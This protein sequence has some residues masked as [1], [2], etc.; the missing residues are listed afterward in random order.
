ML[1]RAIAAAH[2]ALI[3]QVDGHLPRPVRFAVFDA[4]GPAEPEN[5]ASR[6]RLLAS[7][8]LVE[9]ALPVWSAEQPQDD[10]PAQLV[11][12]ALTSPSVAKDAWAA[13]QAFNEEIMDLY[14]AD[15]P[16]SDEG[17]AAGHAVV[18]L[19]A[20][21][22]FGMDRGLWPDADDHDRD[23]DVWDAVYYAEIALTTDDPAQNR[24]ERHALWTWWLDE[25]VPAAAEAGPRPG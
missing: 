8:A 2:E 22:A 11:R 24:D 25:A 7:A 4:L 17:G 13:A 12:A 18:T 19:V 21:G 3:A 6:P 23:P 14:N 10:R 15:E 5:P 16:I 20:E 9:R 1:D